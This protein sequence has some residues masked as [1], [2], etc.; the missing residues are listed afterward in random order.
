MEYGV[1]VCAV[2]FV[3]AGVLKIVR[4]LAYKWLRS[5]LTTLALKLR[6]HE[7]WMPF[8]LSFFHALILVIAVAILVSACLSWG[9]GLLIGLGSLILLLGAVGVGSYVLLLRRQLTLVAHCR[10]FLVTADGLSQTGMSL[11][12]AFF[13]LLNQPKLSGFAAVAE[14]ALGPFRVGKSFSLCVRRLEKR[15]PSW[16]HYFVLLDM[17]QKKGLATHTLLGE[18]ISQLAWRE[19]RRTKELHLLEQSLGQAFIAH[20]LVYFFY[21]ALWM[22]DGETLVCFYQSSLFWPVVG[23]AIAWQMVGLFWLWKLVCV[24][25]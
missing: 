2:M 16:A 17:L 12:S 3:L 21:G 18:L 13:F 7:L 1:S 6:H 8:S 19:E 9:Y 4:V 10:Q 11:A 15:L 14:R 5:P 24:H 25:G 20:S 23:A 22:F